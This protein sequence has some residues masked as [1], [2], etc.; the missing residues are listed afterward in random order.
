MSIRSFLIASICDEVTEAEAKYGPFRSTHEAYGVL[1]E[2]VDELLCAIR[3]CNAVPIRNSA[4]DVAAV[5]LRL[6][7]ACQRVNVRRVAE[8]PDEFEKRSGL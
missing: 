5:A 2:E 3:S 1:A 8:E 4:I 6:A 7:E